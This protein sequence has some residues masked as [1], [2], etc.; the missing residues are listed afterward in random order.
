[1]FNDKF[2]K[3][4][5]RSCMFYFRMGINCLGKITT[6]I[7]LINLSIC[8][9]WALS[10]DDANPQFWASRFPNDIKSDSDLELDMKA[11]PYDNNFTYTNR[12]F[13]PTGS[14]PFPVLVVIPT[15]GGP[16]ASDKY[17]MTEGLSRGYAAIILDTH[18][19]ARHNCTRPKRIGWGRMVK[20]SYDLLEQL[21]KQAY[22]DKNRVYA[23]GGSEGPMNGSFLTSPAIQKM[24]TNNPLRYRAVAGFYGCGI[25]PKGTF[26]GQEEHFPFLFN[27]MNIPML[28][29]A[30]GQDNECKVQADSEVISSMI[31]KKLPIQYHLY[32]TAT[33]CWNCSTKDG[34][35]K[36]QPYVDGSD[37]T[38]RYRYD[39]QITEDSID[40]AFKFF[41][42]NQ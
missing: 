40:R 37:T 28:W 5:E 4:T 42:Q 9:A 19:N 1:M 23:I 18:R 26:S 35:T 8:S 29:L 16:D 21:S 41:G 6:L 15:C 7:F 32:P 39:Q 27:D 11:V 14:G 12:V 30:A 10:A 24:I 25:F 34:F 17:L 2:I 38:V 20:D 3:I 13:V 36:S 31:A 22:V 33:H